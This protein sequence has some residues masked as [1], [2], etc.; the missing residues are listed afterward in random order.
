MDF[1][2]GHTFSQ[3]LLFSSLLV[4]ET[5]EDGTSVNPFYYTTCTIVHLVV[6]RPKCWNFLGLGT[7]IPV[8]LIHRTELCYILEVIHGITKTH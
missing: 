8:L 4:L 6:V 5:V 1:H 7:E 3:M 2:F